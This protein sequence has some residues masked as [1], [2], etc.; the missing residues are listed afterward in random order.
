L[1][2]AARPNESVPFLRQ[3]V[4][5]VPRVN[6]RELARLIHQLNDSSFD[7]REQATQSLIQLGDPIHSRLRTFLKDPGLPS[8]T[9]KR[10]LLILDQGQEAPSVIRY[11]RLIAALEY[12]DDPS[13]RAFL[14]TLAE[15]EPDSPLTKEAKAAYLRHPR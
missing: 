13:A 15:G 10:I 3:H 9:R 12:M 11:Q 14:K 5:P 7:A 8:E 1:T 6:Q 2:F 4:V